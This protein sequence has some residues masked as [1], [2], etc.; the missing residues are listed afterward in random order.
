[1]I[2]CMNRL[3]GCSRRHVDRPVPSPG[4][5]RRILTSDIRLSP[6]LKTRRPVSRVGFEFASMETPGANDGRRTE[7]GW[8][9]GTFPSKSPLSLRYPSLRFCVAS[10]TLCTTNHREPWSGVVHVFAMGSLPGQSGVSAWNGRPDV[11]VYPFIVELL[12]SCSQN[13]N[14]PFFA[15]RLSVS[16]LGYVSK[17]C[18]S[19]H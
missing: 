3:A 18:Q 16:S 15:S 13:E 17:V 11:R 4:P 12:H 19:G 10:F 5:T 8:T 7:E 6:R 1:M 2:F 14:T 9:K